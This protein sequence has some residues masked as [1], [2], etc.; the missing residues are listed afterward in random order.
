MKQHGDDHWHGH[1]E[2]TQ[3]AVKRLYATMAG[4]DGRIRGLDEQRYFEALDKAQAHIDRPVG[5]GLVRNF[6]GTNLTVPYVG[7]GPTTHSAWANPGVQREHFMADPYKSGPENLAI[8]ASYLD[9]A[10][11]AARQ[12]GAAATGPDDILRQE[13]PPLGAAVHSIQDSYSGAHAWREDSVYE[14]NVEAP[15]QS[16]H[17]F[18]PAHAVGIDDGKNTHAD[19]FDKPPIESGSARAATEAT[20]RLLQA[21]EQGYRTSPDQ[22]RAELWKA[23]GPMVTPSA[24]GVTVNTAP[25]AE[26]AA[27][28]DRRVALEHNP[29]GAQFGAEELRVLGDVL[30]TQPGSPL[31]AGPQAATPDGRVSDARPA[32]HHLGRST[33]PDGPAR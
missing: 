19:E 14:G 28:R 12:A 31:S 30:A 7:P 4:P 24:S 13:M 5:A 29:P 21:H 3:E 23:L 9:D 1:R 33:G 17:V 11:A 15:V 27:E 26:W 10:M 25:T 2:I 20:F 16:F 32:S 6:N 18:T 22:A 8:N